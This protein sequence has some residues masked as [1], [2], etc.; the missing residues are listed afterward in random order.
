MKP[1]IIDPEGGKPKWMRWRTFDRLVEQNDQLVGRSMN[2]L[3]EKLELREPWV[4]K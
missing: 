2:A 4:M 3:A 1:G